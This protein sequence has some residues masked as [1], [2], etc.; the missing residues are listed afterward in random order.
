MVYNGL[1][2]LPNTVLGKTDQRLLGKGSKL[3][4]MFYFPIGRSDCLKAILG[5]LWMKGKGPE[6]S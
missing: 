6:M 2:F 3:V 1:S 4:V 5:Y